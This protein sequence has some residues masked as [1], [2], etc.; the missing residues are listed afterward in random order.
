MR[1]HENDGYHYAKLFVDEIPGDFVA[2][3]W[4]YQTVPENR[5][6]APPAPGRGAGGHS[7]ALPAAGG[8]GLNTEAK[9]AIDSA[10]PPIVERVTW[11]R[12]FELEQRS[13]M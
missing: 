11:T 5:D 12:D 13:I 9:L 8:P 6:L 2:L 3:K 7:S 10:I 4:A 1:V